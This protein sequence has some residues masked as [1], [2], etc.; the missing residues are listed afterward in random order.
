MSIYI[1]IDWSQSK[2]DVAFVNESGR[3]VA[4]MTIPHTPKGLRQFDDVRQQFAVAAS[5]CPVALETDD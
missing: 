2:H 5:E 1:G 3:V 4:A